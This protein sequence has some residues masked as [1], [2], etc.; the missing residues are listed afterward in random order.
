M[1][2]GLEAFSFRHK[3]FRKGREFLPDG[4]IPTFLLEASELL[5][6]QLFEL[7]GGPAFNAAVMFHS[8]F[9]RTPALELQQTDADPWKK[10]RSVLRWCGRV[11]T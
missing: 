9:C 4:D 1:A 3:G 11:F 2:L 10:A 8:G 6:L 5:V 7:V